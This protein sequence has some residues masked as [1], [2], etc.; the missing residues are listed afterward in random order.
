ML[1]FQFDSAGMLISDGSPE[2]CRSSMGFVGL[3]WDMSVSDQACR[4]P[5]RHAGL[6]S[7]TS[8]CDGPCRYSM[9][10]IEVSDQ[11]CTFYVNSFSNG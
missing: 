2:A 8:V 11:A 1:K 3:Q 9:K 10:Q 6:R 5:I 4:S 7:D